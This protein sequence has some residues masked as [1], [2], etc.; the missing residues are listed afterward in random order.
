MEETDTSTVPGT[1]SDMFCSRISEWYGGFKRIHLLRTAIDLGM[2]DPGSY[3]DSSEGLIERLSLDPLEGEIFLECLQDMGLLER[4]EQGL[5]LSRI[6]REFL[7]EDSLTNQLFFIGTTLRN[8]DRWPSY[9]EILHNGPTRIDIGNGGK[10]PES[11]FLYGIGGLAT[12]AAERAASMMELP[13]RPSV[14]GIGPA[15][16]IFVAALSELKNAGMSHIMVDETMI[17]TGK[18]VMVRIGA[19][20]DFIADSYGSDSIDTYDLI[21]TAYHPATMDVHI[22][23]RIADRLGD[24]GYLFVRRHAPKITLDPFTDLDGNLAFPSFIDVPKR[25]HHGDENGVGYISSLK[26]KG[27]V[28]LDRYLYGA[29]SEIFLFKKDTKVRT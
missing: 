1:E 24:G 4:T 18:D 14:L 23:G 11:L 25:H 13:E 20:T 12:Y 7:T 3:P 28:L 8:I 2:F 15:S 19:A 17:S 10:V 22:G 27:V 9:S 26:S 29:D 5:D 21:I 16:S 6:G